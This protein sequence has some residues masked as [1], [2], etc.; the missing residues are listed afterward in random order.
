MDLSGN[1]QDTNSSSTTILDEIKKLVTNKT[2]TELNEN[3]SFQDLQ[4][5]SNVDVNHDRNMKNNKENVLDKMKSQFS[6]QGQSFLHET[7]TSDL[8]DE[9]NL[10]GSVKKQ[11][12]Y[13]GEYQMNLNKSLLV[14]DAT[15]S[16]IH[17]M[18]EEENAE[19]SSSNESLL[20][21]SPVLF[22]NQKNLQS[23]GVKRLFDEIGQK[24]PLCASTPLN[25][26][27][28]LLAETNKLNQQVCFFV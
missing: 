16:P 8:K 13:D 6:T 11:M 1:L 17:S 24:S 3:H 20:L 5:Y 10:G 7:K 23:R 26:N 4:Q 9:E 14:N 19:K 25:N 28:L 27:K 21:K 2:I 15:F 18:F 12:R 22:T